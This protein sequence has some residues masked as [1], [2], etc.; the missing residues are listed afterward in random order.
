MYTRCLGF[1]ECLVVALNGVAANALSETTI[2]QVY[3]VTRRVAGEK[4]LRCLLY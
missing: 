2:G 4:D 3:L 1:N